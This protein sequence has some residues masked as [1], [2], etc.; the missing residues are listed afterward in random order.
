MKT[1]L[2]E[3]A[4][5]ELNGATLGTVNQ[6]TISGAVELFGTSGNAWVS[7]MGNGVSL[8][9]KTVTIS[10]GLSE[11]G[12]DWALVEADILAQLGLTKAADQNPAPTQP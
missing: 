7:L 4:P 12:A 10:E 5:V 1:I 11:S 3:S 9:N 2:V 6:V 8:A